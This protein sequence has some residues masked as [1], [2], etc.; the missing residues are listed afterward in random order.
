MFPVMQEISKILYFR[1]TIAYLQCPS[2]SAYVS[3]KLIPGNGRK[4]LGTF[5]ILD[6]TFLP[7]QV[8][9]VSLIS[10]CHLQSKHTVPLEKSIIMVQETNVESFYQLYVPTTYYYPGTHKYDLVQLV[11]ATTSSQSRCFQVRLFHFKQNKLLLP[12]KFFS[13]NFYQDIVKTSKGFIL[14]CH[15]LS[16]YDSDAQMKWLSCKTGRA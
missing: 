9:I 2:G 12:I 4:C 10:L 14:S 5:Y 6:L 7:Q 11:T 3:I 16:F 13:G 15:L 8:R 1:I